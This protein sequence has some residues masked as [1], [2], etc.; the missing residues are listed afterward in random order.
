MKYDGHT[1]PE[2]IESLLLIQSFANRE[3]INISELKVDYES[4][5]RL[6]LTQDN[7]KT[8]DQGFVTL[9]SPYGYLKIT[10]GDD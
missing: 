2:I 10:R 7:P 6:L 9:K 1:S 5:S 8:R 4:Y 3:H